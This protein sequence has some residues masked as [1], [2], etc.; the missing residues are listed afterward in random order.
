[1][2]LMKA[3]KL[4]PKKKGNVCGLTE[5]EKSIVNLLDSEI[6]RDLQEALGENFMIEEPVDNITTDGDVDYEKELLWLALN[7]SDI[8]LL[9]NIIDDLRELNP[10]KWR[11]LT[12]ELYPSILMQPLNIIKTF[13]AQE[14]MCIGK[15]L[16]QQTRC[17][18]CKSNA[19]KA[20]NANS[21]A[22]AFMG[23]H[24]LDIKQRPAI[25]RKQIQTLHCLA[26]KVIMD[27][28]YKLIQ[29]QVS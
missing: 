9:T 11:N 14:I 5:L 12:Q 26:K 22:Q 25:K 10:E 16:E 15:T 19:Q 20:V 1:M 29:L 21:L 8:S 2:L 4:I 24:F 18:F 3:M 27:D 7:H 17:K 28:E 23:E 6:V 13:S